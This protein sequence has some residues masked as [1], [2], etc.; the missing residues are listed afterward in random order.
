MCAW[1]QR[2]LCVCVWE[3]ISYAPFPALPSHQTV[4]VRVCVRKEDREREIER[5]DVCLVCVTE[6]KREKR[7]VC[8]QPTAALT[9]FLTPCI[10][11]VATILSCPFDPMCTTS[12]SSFSPHCCR[13][14][15]TSVFRF[16]LDPPPLRIHPRSGNAS[17]NLSLFHACPWSWSEL[18][19]GWRA[20]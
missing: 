15:S 12:S 13:S 16:P 8:C 17:V 3:Q 10:W 20:R 1:E 2:C 4:C 11:M 6:Q 19:R 7:T 9:L 18:N 5:V 14:R